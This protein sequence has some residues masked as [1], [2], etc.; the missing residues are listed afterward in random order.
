[1]NR[2]VYLDSNATTKTAPQI[3]ES[4]LPYFY[5][6]FGNPSSFYS[7]GKKVKNAIEKARGQ[8]AATIGAQ[9]NNIIFTSGGSESNC[10][11]IWSAL[12]EYPSKNKIVT[13]KIEHASLL[14]FINN[15]T[16]GRFKCKVEFIEVNENGRLSP[17]ALAAAIDANTAI[18]SLQ[19]ANNETG[20]ILN[21]EEC[22]KVVTK[23]RIQHQFLFH[24]DA[25]QAL[26]KMPLDFSV[27]SQVDLASFSG[28]KIHAPKGVGFLYVENPAIFR[29]L[30]AGHQESGMRG[31]TENVA[32]IIALG[33][34]CAEVTK[35]LK[36]N[37]AKELKIRHLLEKKLSGIK[38]IK[39]NCLLADRLPNTVSISFD[40]FDGNKML[41]ALEKFGICVSTGSACSSTV[42]APSHVLVA[43]KIK[44]YENTI[45][46]SIDENTTEDQIDYFLKMLKDI[47]KEK[48]K[49]ASDY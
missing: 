22:L 47:L 44:N 1:M 30:I 36:Y 37:I 9:P 42:P 18:V 23:K 12:Q 31:G 14:E 7:F 4:C 15:L 46:I 39:V 33:E 35:N 32:G 41:L 13:T 3:V 24:T 11:A 40:N 17:M 25:V 16:D 6:Q 49:N 43:M 29:P 48:K 34:A 10:A 8:V 20:T 26:G 45:R 21:F 28:H 2:F 27:W 38:G 19:L 5:A